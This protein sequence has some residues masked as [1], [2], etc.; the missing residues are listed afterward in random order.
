[1]PS[2]LATTKMSR[3]PLWTIISKSENPTY[4]THYVA[5]R[6]YELSPKLTSS[7]AKQI[8]MCFKSPSLW[9]PAL[10]VILNSRGQLSCSSFMTKFQLRTQIV[11][12]ACKV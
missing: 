7:W 6:I 5:Y 1:L 10:D 2:I 11:Y 12:I 8:V 4:L 3:L 9:H